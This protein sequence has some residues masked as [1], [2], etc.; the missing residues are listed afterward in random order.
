M[1]I[2]VP[3]T[4]TKCTYVL[5]NQLISRKGLAFHINYH[6][7]IINYASLYRI[8]LGHLLSVALDDNDW[9]C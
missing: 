3:L 9:R 1:Y 7:M 2:H 5:R 6:D 8:G 4:P